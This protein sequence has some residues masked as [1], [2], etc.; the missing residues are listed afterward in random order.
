L[1]VFQKV[2][3][4]KLTRKDVVIL[5]IRGINLD[6][7]IRSELEQYNFY[8]ARWSPD[9]LIASS[10]FR[11]YAD[12]KPSFFVCL[13]E[14][15]D[16]Y[17]CWKDSGAIDPE[18]SSGGFVKLLSFLRNEDYESTIEYLLVTYASSWDGNPDKITLDTSKYRFEATKQ[19]IKAD[20]LD[21]YKFRHP[22]FGKRGISEKVQRLYN[23]GYDKRT[24]S[25]T[26]PWYNAD[27]TLANVKYRRTDSKIFWYTKDAVPI[28]RLLYGINVI[29]AQRAKTSVIC[30]GESDALSFAE[31]GIPAIGIGGSSFNTTK[32]DLIVRSPI[33]RLI[34][35]T[36]ND[37]VG[38][39]IRDDIVASLAGRIELAEITWPE[40]YKDANDVLVNGEGNEELHSYV[41]E[42]KSIGMVNFT[43]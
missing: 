18:W 14:T 2:I 28:S 37:V 26:L 31:A 3:I 32:A 29:Y 6:I 9:K 40:R 5:R 12:S 42:A 8:R 25:I 22:Y 20:I 34:I 13:D 41:D 43:L 33:E 39:K 4:L 21:K 24:K 15:S 17:G 11:Y 1:Q 7:N 19:R 35:G 16:Y 10:P 30:E 38:R 36:D 23:V 27:Q